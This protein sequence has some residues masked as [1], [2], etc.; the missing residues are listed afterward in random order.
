MRG[1]HTHTYTRSLNF[2]VAFVS[3]AGIDKFKTVALKLLEMKSVE[4]LTTYAYSAGNW[5]K[6]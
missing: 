4:S 5:V 1:I 6:T 2:D 3:G